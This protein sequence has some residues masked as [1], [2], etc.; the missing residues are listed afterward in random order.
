MRVRTS[1]TEGEGKTVFPHSKV[2]PIAQRLL[3][4]APLPN[5]RSLAAITIAGM[6]KDESGQ[7]YRDIPWNVIEDAAKKLAAK[8]Y[9]G[10]GQSVS[11][12]L[13]LSR[14]S[15]VWQSVYHK[16]QGGA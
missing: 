3:H 10:P 1:L 8:E 15:E 9:A 7:W 5:Q 4:S 6:L 2:Q 11:H 16:W 12:T 14:I 13:A